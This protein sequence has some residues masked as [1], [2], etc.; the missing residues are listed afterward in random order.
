MMIYMNM[1]YINENTTAILFHFKYKK[2]KPTIYEIPLD[3]LFHRK[4]R[5]DI[6]AMST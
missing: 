2:K 6:R 1:L 3:N 4:K 5:G